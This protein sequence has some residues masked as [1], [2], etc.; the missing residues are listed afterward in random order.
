MAQQEDHGKGLRRARSVE[1]ARVTEASVIDE[2][3]RFGNRWLS[4]GYDQ[5]GLIARGGFG[6]VWEARDARSTTVAV[7][8]VAKVVTRPHDVEAAQREIA[9][10]ELLSSC[11]MQDLSNI[12]RVLQTFETRTDIW[13]VMEHGG[14]PLSKVLFTTRGEFY[15]GERV[16]RVV[17]QPLYAA[18]REETAPRVLAQI[19]RQ[20][21]IGLSVLSD[22][23]IKHEDLKPDNVLVAVAGTSI[24]LRLADFGAAYVEGEAPPSVT[25]TPEYMSPER[26][27]GKLYTR[28]SPL[29]A[30][31]MW[32]AGCLLLEVVHGV[33]LWIAYKTLVVRSG[34]SLTTTGLLAVPGRDTGKILRRQRELVTK[35][36]AVLAAGVGLRVPPLFVELLQRL[37]A[38][39]PHQRPAPAESLAHAYLHDAPDVGSGCLTS[40]GEAGETCS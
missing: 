19:T 35:L 11:G 32:S 1:V 4:S 6:I 22:L 15:R 25:G 20:L 38:M 28:P 10:A 36:P 3:A 7:K 31:D 8:Q 37:L 23:C 33:P 29:H 26:L 21:L 30:A 40:A 2:E 17:D 27:D 12:V 34:R 39:P 5:V 9:I 18:M 13:I 24:H 16:Y 14:Q